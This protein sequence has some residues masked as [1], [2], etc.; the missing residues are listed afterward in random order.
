MDIKK[1]ERKEE[2]KYTRAQRR[3]LIKL[4]DQFE[5]LMEDYLHTRAMFGDASD[6][7]VI[8]NK[9]WQAICQKHNSQ[10]RHQINADPKAFARQ[11][12]EKEKL[13]KVMQAQMEK[14]ME[15]RAYEDWMKKVEM[16]FP[17]LWYRWSIL[18]KMLKYDY[19]K[20]RYEKFQGKSPRGEWA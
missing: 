15:K 2:P 7:Y 3:E 19:V 20:K 9:K 6:R 13:E 17:F 5:D 18:N 1:P 11:V 12:D 4:S 16:R 10:K 14:A 8:L